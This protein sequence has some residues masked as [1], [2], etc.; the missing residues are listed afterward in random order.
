MVQ[1]AE[2]ALME[3]TGFH[4]GMALNLD[5]RES[6]AQFYWKAIGPRLSGSASYAG[7]AANLTA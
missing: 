2:V 1:V 7:L 4:H 3:G 6:A 5:H